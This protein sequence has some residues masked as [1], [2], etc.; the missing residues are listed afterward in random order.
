MDLFEKLEDS[1]QNLLPYDGTV[2]YYGNVMSQ[3]RCWRVVF[4]FVDD[5]RLAKR[6]LDDLW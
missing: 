1:R 6:S 5:N 3:K 2:H 4:V